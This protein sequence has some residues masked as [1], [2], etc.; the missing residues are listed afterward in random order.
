MLKTAKNSMMYTKFM[1]VIMIPEESDPIPNIKVAMGLAFPSR[2]FLLNAPIDFAPKTMEII[3]NGKAVIIRKRP[4][5]I[6]SSS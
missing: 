5:K 1:K 4:V 3:D 2:P 6:A